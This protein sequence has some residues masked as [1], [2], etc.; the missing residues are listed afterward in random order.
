MKT[1]E[2]REMIIAGSYAAVDRC[3]RDKTWSD[4]RRPGGE[5]DELY[6]LLDAPRERTN[7]IDQ[8]PGQAQRLARALGSVY[9]SGAAQVEVKSIQGKY[10]LASSGIA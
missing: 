1:D 5:P 4:V 8:R 2:H 10:E 9:Q 3:V 6:N 7:L